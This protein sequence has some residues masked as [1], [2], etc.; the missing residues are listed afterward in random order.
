MRGHDV[1]YHQARYT[2]RRRL[3]HRFILRGIGFTLLVKPEVEGREHIP[4]SGPTLLIM[5]HI[6]AIDPFVVVGVVRSRFVVPMSKI[7][8][9]QNPVVGLMARAW[10]IYPVRREEV[11]RK[12]LVSTLELLRQERPVLIAPEGTRQPALAAAKHGMT[13]IAT[14]A[15]AA[16][17]PIGLEG[18]DV[19]PGTLKRLRRARVTVRIGRAFR[20]QTGGRQRVP[21]DELHR[22]TQE[23]MCQL[24]GLLPEHRRG[25]YHDLAQATSDTLEFLT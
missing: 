13:Y 5:N 20:F 3:I 16:V 25:V 19:F 8:N 24:A 9:F 1:V 10:G 21:R 6:A 15:D 7:E 23:A 17:V 2:W 22:M 12:A 4:D 18:T 11:D 14:K